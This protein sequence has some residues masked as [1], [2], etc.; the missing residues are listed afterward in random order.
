[1]PLHTQKVDNANSTHKRTIKDNHLNQQT[2]CGHFQFL[3]NRLQLSAWL[4]VVWSLR[5]YGSSPVTKQTI[6]DLGR[7]PVLSFRLI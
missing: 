2:P 3:V 1:M 5:F 6:V 4:F 7:Q